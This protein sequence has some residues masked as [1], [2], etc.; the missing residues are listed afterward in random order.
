MPTRQI[1]DPADVVGRQRGGVQGAADTLEG[2]SANGEILALVPLKHLVIRG[3]RPNNVD[4]VDR[5]I[6]HGI[7]IPREALGK[8]CGCQLME[9]GASP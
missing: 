3:N 7:A 8:V 5:R 1:K 2:G 6:R 9:K 4:A